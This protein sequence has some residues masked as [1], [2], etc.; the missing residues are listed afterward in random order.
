MVPMRDLILFD[1]QGGNDLSM[2]LEVVSGQENHPIMNDVS[3]SFTINTGFN[4]GLIHSFAQNPSTV[5]MKQGTNDAVAYRNFGNGHVLNFHNTGNYLNNKTSLNEIN[6]QKIIAN[7]ILADLVDPNFV[8]KVE[9]KKA[10]KLLF[11]NT[12]SNLLFFNNNVQ[13][14]TITVY[15]SVGQIVIET[16]SVSDNTLNISNLNAG[17]YFIKTDGFKPEKFIK[18]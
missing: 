14:K 17:I 5:L 18:K 8:S 11:N 13:G 6:I 3:A 15:N 1:R 16:S 10:D 7:F 4:E 12:S 2:L 9:T